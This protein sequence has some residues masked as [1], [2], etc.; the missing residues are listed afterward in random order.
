MLEFLCPPHL[1]FGNVPVRRVWRLR[2]CRS[3]RPGSFCSQFSS[4]LWSLFP[5][6]PTFPD[7]PYASSHFPRDQ[8]HSRKRHQPLRT[9]PPRSW[10]GP[11]TMAGRY[12]VRGRVVQTDPRPDGIE[13]EATAAGFSLNR[14]KTRRFFRTESTRHS[15]L[16]QFDVDNGYAGFLSNAL[17]PVLVPHSQRASARIAEL[18]DRTGGVAFVFDVQV[19][20]PVA[21][22][23]AVL[24]HRG[25]VLP[26]G[27]SKKT[28]PPRNPKPLFDAFCSYPLTHDFAAKNVVSLSLSTALACGMLPN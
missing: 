15:G 13:E 20:G 18:S 17:E 11:C 4:S 24:R 21:L 19:H 14:T 5:P 28:S 3:P 25:A 9:W 2:G 7:R 27:E 23:L 6:N 8:P 12:Q 22:L 16:L 26:V 10:I 1:R